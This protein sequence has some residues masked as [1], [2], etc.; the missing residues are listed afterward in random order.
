MVISVLVPFL[1]TY[2]EKQK[3]QMFL[4]K[5][6][7]AM[8]KGQGQGLWSMDKDDGYMAQGGSVG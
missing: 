5:A 6:K 3:K 8:D 1:F 7:K 2:P 4:K